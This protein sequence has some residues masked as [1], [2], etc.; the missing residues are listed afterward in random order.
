MATR[1]P[2]VKPPPS[3]AEI[4]GARERA[5]LTQSEAGAMVHGNDRLWR[6]WESG[7]HRM[8]PGL[9]ELFLIKVSQRQDGNA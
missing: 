9:F 8:P 6:Y 7:T 3:A 4:R 1:E 2:E 5:G